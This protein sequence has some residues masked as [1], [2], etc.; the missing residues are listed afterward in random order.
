M[1]SLRFFPRWRPDDPYQVIGLLRLVNDILAE[2]PQASRWLEIGSY[3]GE[4]AT[5]FL[6]FP[7]VATLDCVDSWQAAC[8]GLRARFAKE[9]AAGRCR[10]HQMP[11]L[12]FA[13]AASEYDVVYI[14]GD[15][16][17]E[18]VRADIAAYAGKLAAGGFLAGHD[19]HAGYPGVIQAVD[20]W[21][22]NKP[23]TVYEDGSWCVRMPL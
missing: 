17:Y 6:G 22:E 21:R 9:I 4:S 12:T 23:V 14:D 2:S 11:S 7:Q 20:E 5:L 15:H 1:D 19:Y 10:V 8:D 3:R 18:A 13:K 16:S